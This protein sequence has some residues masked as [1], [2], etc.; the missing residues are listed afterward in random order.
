MKDYKVPEFVKLGTGGNIYA[1]LTQ[2]QTHFESKGVWEYI[3]R[4]EELEIPEESELTE[5]RV[6]A[7]CK[8]I[9]LQVFMKT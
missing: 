8:E 2:M 1:W 6:A 4:N 5:E 7:L 3:E 9:Y